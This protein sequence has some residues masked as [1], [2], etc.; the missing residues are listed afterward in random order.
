M[1]VGVHAWGGQKP[2]LGFIFNCSPFYLIICFLIYLL[3]FRQD[4]SVHLEFMDW[5]ELLTNTL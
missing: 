5:L 1:F 3:T 2:M 4:L